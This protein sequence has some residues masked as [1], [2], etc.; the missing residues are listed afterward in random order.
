MMIRLKIMI[1]HFPSFD[2]DKVCEYYTEKDGAPV[3]YVCTSAIESEAFAMDI[4]YRTTP[5]P[6]FGN[7][8]F[9]LY[10]RGGDTMITNADKI[11]GAEF[12]LINDD[13]GNLQYSAHRHDHKQFKNGNMID[14][15]RAYVRCS[16]HVTYARV[17]DGKMEVINE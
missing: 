7:R 15:G 12:G 13:D 4:F 10:Q 9:G 8:Y 16:G 6:I 11:D 3:T 2:I 5:H 1:K 17:H 14:G